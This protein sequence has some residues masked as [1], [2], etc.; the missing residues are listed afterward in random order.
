MSQIEYNMMV[1]SVTDRSN[2]LLDNSQTFCRHKEIV[3]LLLLALCNRFG[4]LD[5]SLVLVMRKGLSVHSNRLASCAWLG[6][7]IFAQYRSL[8]NDKVQ[9]IQYLENTRFATR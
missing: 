6:N 3:V 8:S 4:G 5:C 2:H 9:P 7:S 1:A